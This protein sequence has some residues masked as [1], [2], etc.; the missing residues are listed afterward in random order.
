MDL[1][2]HRG[3][4]DE[5]DLHRERGSL[6]DDERAMAAKFRTLV[7][8]IPAV[9]YVDPLDPPSP[10]VS[11]YVSPQVERMF[12]VPKESTTTDR[13]WWIRLVH[14]DDRQRVLAASDEADRTRGPYRIEYRMRT[15]DGLELWVHDEA[16]LVHDEDGVP[17]FWQGVMYDISDQK[18]AEQELQQALQMERRALR[19]LEEANELKDAV[20]AGP[21]PEVL[22]A[23]DGILASALALEAR[24]GRVASD[25]ERRGLV[26]G[27]VVDARR[28][29][30]AFHARP[31]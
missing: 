22:E 5:V 20:R 14:P 15:V 31:D 30:A 28:L 3:R 21:G 13:D 24:E 26:A 2:E 12:G 23:L 8:Q 29:R 16:M 10:A 27:L 1:H 25:D 17:I 4:R 11:L 19:R 9:V 7:E 18:R 6:K